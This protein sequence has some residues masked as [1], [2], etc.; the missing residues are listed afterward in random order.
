MIQAEVFDDALEQANE[1]LEAGYKDG[2]CIVAGVVL[3][4]TLKELSARNSIPKN[5]LDRINTDL[6]KA[7]VYNMGMQ[8]QITAW[9]ERRNKAAHGEWNE[10]NEADVKD[11][12]RGVNRL[13]A[14]YL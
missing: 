5:K 3:E 11:L 7:G 8:K 13:I 1:L 6:C 9:A 2:A 12:I 14:E 10:Y 4:T